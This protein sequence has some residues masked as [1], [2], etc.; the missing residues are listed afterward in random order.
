MRHGQP[1][2]FRGPSTRA[3]ALAQDDIPCKRLLCGFGCG[4]C[5]VLLLIVGLFSN[6]FHSAAKLRVRSPGQPAYAHIHGDSHAQ[7]RACA[8]HQNHVQDR[9]GHRCIA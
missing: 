4:C 9:D 2:H 7:Q 1:K 8:N 6:I 3:F 5:V